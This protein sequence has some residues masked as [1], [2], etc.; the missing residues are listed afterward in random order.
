MGLRAGKVAMYEEWCD[1]VEQK[2]YI[3]RSRECVKILETA[4]FGSPFC[5]NPDNNIGVT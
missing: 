3:Q 1:Y 4:N 2:V 5:F